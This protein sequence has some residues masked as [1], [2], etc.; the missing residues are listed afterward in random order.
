MPN[1]L[2]WALMHARPT[3]SAAGKSCRT[4]GENKC[5]DAPYARR[6]MD[7][8]PVRGAMSTAMPRHFP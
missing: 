1:L 4:P 2:G 8:Y 7:G 3:E 5:P 6:I